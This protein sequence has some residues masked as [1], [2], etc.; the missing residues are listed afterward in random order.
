LKKNIQSLFIKTVLILLLSLLLIS[1]F[2]AIGY[3]QLP[4]ASITLTKTP[5]ATK[6]LPG[7]SVSY[8]YN[9]T[10]TGEVPLTGAI[11]DDVYGTVGSFVDLQPGGWVAY[12]VT[13]VITENTT[14]I[15]TAY[16][17]DSYGQNATSTDTAFVQAYIPKASICLKKI[18]SASKVLSGSS[19]SYL[20]K[21]TNTGDTV[22]NGS[23]TDDKLGFIGIFTDLEPGSMVCFTE[24]CALTSDTYNVA[25]AIATDSFGQ[26][27]M[28]TDCAFVRVVCPS[29]SAVLTVISPNGGESVI[30]GF[31]HTIRWSSDGRVGY[32][33][34]IELLKDGI[35]DRVLVSKTANDGYYKWY[36]PSWLTPGTDYKIRIT[37]TYRDITDSSDCSFTI[38][39]GKERIL[40]LT[41]PK[42]GEQWRHGTTHTITW[43]K[44]G[45]TGSYVRI[46]LLK[47]GVVK[48]TIAYR[49]AND[50]Y[51]RWYIPSWLTPGT[52]YQIRITSTAYMWINDLSNFIIVT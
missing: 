18:P 17:V 26:Q 42:S 37:S 10:N 23:V 43:L 20:Y 46:E 32:Y 25:T 2:A 1:T 45:R 29:P 24:Y 30:P 34:K 4:N 15:A 39:S 12:N 28:A 27:V 6:V 38:V 50:G 22:L 41:S 44:S 33:V 36:I 3:S 51:Y 19:V 49:T 11:Y 21:V 40:T 16:G 5:S 31:S 7:S 35:V 9:A 8:L 52:D 48:R 47:G 14:N 13:H